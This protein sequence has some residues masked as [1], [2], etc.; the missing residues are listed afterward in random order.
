[1]SEVRR[2]LLILAIME[3]CYDSARR[4]GE[5]AVEAERQAFE[6]RDWINEVTE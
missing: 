6:A 1:M 4:C 3:Y 5:T 2:Y